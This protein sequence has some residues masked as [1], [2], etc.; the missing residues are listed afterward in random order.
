[1]RRQQFG[2]LSAAAAV[3]LGLLAAGCNSQASRAVPTIDDRATIRYL[4]SPELEGRGMGTQGLDRAAAFIAGEFKHLGLRPLPGRKDFFQTFEV[5]YHG[6]P[7]QT[8]NVIGYIR[9][10]RAKEYLVIGAHFDHL[11]RDGIGPMRG[12]IHPGADDNASGTTALLML[13]SRIA[14]RHQPPER[15]IIF[16]AF[17]AE[18]IGARGSRYFV[19]NPPVPLS[20]IVAML[21]FDMVGHLRSISTS[22]T[23]PAAPVLYVLGSGT[24]AAFDDMLR[25]VDAQSPI[26]T[27]DLDRGGLGPS[28]HMSFA[29][30]KIPVIF[31]C[32]G[33][34]PDYHRP[35]DVSD[36]I[37][38]RGLEEV[39]DF[40]ANLTDRMLAMPRQQYVSA[41]DVPSMKIQFGRMINALIAAPTTQ[42]Y[43][44]TK[45]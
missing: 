39:V 19:N 5:N 35:T 27:I 20:Q 1:M 3:S 38:Y 45:P 16:A 17:S 25:Q 2:F 29:L 10:K 42:G 40:A 13:A 8:K 36:K 23:R 31:L 41:Y 6:S 14:S 32:T 33:L 7:V 28:D 44:S 43:S 9:G 37:N 24:A 21:N 26:Q 18:E 12:K 30:K 34:F 15:S 22:T 4:A 11:G